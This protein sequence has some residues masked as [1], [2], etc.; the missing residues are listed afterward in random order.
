MNT[1]KKIIYTLRRA[2]KD[3]V[4][5]LMEEAAKKEEIFAKIMERS[6]KDGEYTD[7]AEGTEHYSRRRGIIQ[8]ASAAA[9][10]VSVLR[11]QVRYCISSTASD[12]PRDPSAFTSPDPAAN[13]DSAHDAAAAAE[14]ISAVHAFVFLFMVTFP[15]C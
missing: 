6:G 10:S 12:S 15:F 4:E 8:T 11:S 13:A 2:D 3:S 14:M 9:A 1:R 7:V 5:R